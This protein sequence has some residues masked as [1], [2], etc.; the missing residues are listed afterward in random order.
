L[1]VS[2]ASPAEANEIVKTAANVA[3]RREDIYLV[4]S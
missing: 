4:R 1:E 2:R 3:A